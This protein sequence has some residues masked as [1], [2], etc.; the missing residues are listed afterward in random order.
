MRPSSAE[1]LSG[2]LEVLGEAP[3]NIVYLFIFPSRLSYCCLFVSFLRDRKR[4]ISFV[5]DVVIKLRKI[6]IKAFISNYQV[7][8]K[9]KS[10]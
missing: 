9:I 4:A 1:A 8:E 6:L 5:T 2:L 3:R 10:V 7:I